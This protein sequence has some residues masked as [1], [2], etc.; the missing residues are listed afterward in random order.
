MTATATPTGHRP[1][2]VRTTI[3]V[4]AFLGISAVAGGVALVLGIGA[5]PPAD[6]LDDIPFIDSWFAPGLVLG[7]GFGVGS[8][9]AAYGML[10]RPR[11]AWLSFAERLTRHHWSWIAT[12]LLGVGHVAWIVLEWIYLREA[13]VLQAVYGATGIALVALP[14][15]PVVRRH[16]ALHLTPIPL[17]VTRPAAGSVGPRRRTTDSARPLSEGHRPDQ[18][19]RP[20]SFRDCLPGL[21]R[22]PTGRSVRRRCP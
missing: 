17:T 22:R 10:C 18:R 3:G 11:W 4:L 2:T 19:M 13:S 5:A 12:I 16:L 14:M 15:H 21:P 8:L 6:W 9:L 20:R 1:A 7:I